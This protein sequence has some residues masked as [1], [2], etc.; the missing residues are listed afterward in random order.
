MDFGQRRVILTLGEV[1]SFIRKLYIYIVGRPTEEIVKNKK[2]LIEQGQRNIDDARFIK[3]HTIDIALNHKRWNIVVYEAQRV[4]ELLLKG[5]ICL[6]G[7][8]PSHTHNFSN[9]VD[10][11]CNILP[12]LSRIPTFLATYTEDGSGYGVQINEDEIRFYRRDGVVYTQLGSGSSLSAQRGELFNAD[13][14]AN[15]SIRVKNGTITLLTDGQEISSEADPTYK[16]QAEIERG[17]VHQPNYYRVEQ[18]KKIGKKLRRNREKA[19]YGEHAF[20]QEQAEKARSLMHE[21]NKA[22]SC[23]FC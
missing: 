19:F 8:S 3:E 21:A 11:L 5:I 12:T 10:E 2:Q 23:F 17:F 14:L 20:T 16:G 13:K 4:T 7:H 9:L 1:R 6:T 15:V 18:L 22:A